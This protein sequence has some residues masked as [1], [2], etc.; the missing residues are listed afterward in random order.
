MNAILEVRTCTLVEHQ[1]TLRQISE[2]ENTELRET[3]KYRLQYARSLNRALE[4]KLRAVLALPEMDL[5][6]QFQLR[7]TNVHP[8]L[9]NHPVFAQLKAGTDQLYGGLD[10]FFKQVGMDQLP[11]PGLQNGSMNKGARATLVEF[12]DSY[13]MPFDLRQ[14]EKA[15]WTTDTAGSEDPAM[16]FLQNATDDNARMIYMAFPFSLE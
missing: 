8:P 2:Q 11:C 9:N 1:A 7:S 6:K 12:L 16:L 3:L 4:R 14:I 5:I 13:A 15:I 10:S